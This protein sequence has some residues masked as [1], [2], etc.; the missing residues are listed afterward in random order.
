M[1]AHGPPAHPGQVTI[2]G[3]GFLIIERGCNIKL[4][5][6]DQPGARSEVPPG[7][8]PAL[9]TNRGA[10][11][12]EVSFDLGDKTETWGLPLSYWLNHYEKRMDFH[13]LD[14]NGKDYIKNIHDRTEKD[15][16]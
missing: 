13:I 8:Y 2:L 16:L 15:T 5:N 9:M 10:E 6:P 14:P 7:K 3:K 12:V 4:M 1:N 11:W